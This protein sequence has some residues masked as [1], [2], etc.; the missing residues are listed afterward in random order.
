MKNIWKLLKMMKKREMRYLE[1]F[2]ILSAMT[3]STE[4]VSSTLF[5]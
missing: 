1:W 4:K 3:N 5:M 2:S